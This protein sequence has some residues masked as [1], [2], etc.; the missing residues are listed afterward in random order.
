[1]TKSIVKIPVGEPQY[2][3][4]MHLKANDFN[5]AKEE[6]EKNL[7]SELDAYENS[8]KRI[9]SLQKEVAKDNFHLEYL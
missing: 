7:K 2:Y 4:E 5:N 8:V 1:M 9:K 3:F 6:I